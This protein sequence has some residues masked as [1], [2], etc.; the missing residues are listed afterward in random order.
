MLF[1]GN[2]SPAYVDH[3]SE[4]GFDGIE[5][6]GV[7]ANVEAFGERCDERGLAFVYM[8]G[9]CPPLNRPDRFDDAVANVTETIALAER[10]SYQNLNVKADRVQ[11]DLDEKR[12]RENVA[13]VLREV[14]PVAESPTLRS[15][16]SPQRA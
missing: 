8:S 12:Q 9:A 16:W 3:V 1:D 7:D 14:A 13:S 6:Y 15:Y 2:P 5:L 4:A 10:V 11:D